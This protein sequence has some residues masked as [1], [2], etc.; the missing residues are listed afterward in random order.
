MDSAHLESNGK[1]DHM[2]D[3]KRCGTRANHS[4]GGL[5]ANLMERGSN[6]FA[7]TVPVPYL[8]VGIIS[9]DLT[10]GISGTHYINVHNEKPVNGVLCHSSYDSI[11][12]T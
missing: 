11:D 4:L 3:H 6:T 1:N 12:P 8:D 7:N 2:D 10:T 5:V 9:N